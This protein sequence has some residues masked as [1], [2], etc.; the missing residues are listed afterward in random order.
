MRMESADN[1][2]NPAGKLSQKYNAQKGDGYWIIPSTSSATAATHAVVF[3]H[4]GKDNALPKF[5]N[6]TRAAFSFL[7]PADRPLLSSISH[8]IQW[9]E[10]FARFDVV[11]AGESSA[12][13]RIYPLEPSYLQQSGINV[14][15][16][17]FDVILLK[18][19]RH[20]LSSLAESLDN[21][22]GY[23]LI[24]WHICRHDKP[25]VIEKPYHL[26][27]VNRVSD[28]TQLRLFGDAGATKP[29][30][31]YG[32]YVTSYLGELIDA[33]KVFRDPNLN[34]VS[35]PWLEKVSQL[36]TTF[37]GPA[38]RFAAEVDLSKA[39]GY[40]DTGLVGRLEQ[41]R[42]SIESIV[43]HKLNLDI[44]QQTASTNIPG[45]IESENAASLSQAIGSALDYYRDNIDGDDFQV[46]RF[47]SE[48]GFSHQDRVKLEKIQAALDNG[49]VRVNAVTHDVFSRLGKFDQYFAEVS[50]GVIDGDAL[51]IPWAEGLSTAMQLERLQD[52][53]F[54]PLALGEVFDRVS[55][56]SAEDVSDTYGSV[57]KSNIPGVLIGVEVDA[58]LPYEQRVAAQNTQIQKNLDI[59]AL[60]LDPNSPEQGLFARQ[61]NTAATVS[62][63]NSDLINDVYQLDTGGFV[64]GIDQASTSTH[65][66]AETG[67][68]GVTSYLDRRSQN[69]SKPDIIGHL[70][71]GNGDASAQNLVVVYHELW[72]VISQSR[73][74]EYDANDIPV[75]RLHLDGEKQFGW[76]NGFDERIAGG[77]RFVGETPFIDK[78]LETP[79]GWISET[80][81]SEARGL[82]AELFYPVDAD[83]STHRTSA[84]RSF[85]IPDS[86]IQ[87]RLQ[88][89]LL[90]DSAVYF[91]N[92]YQVF[93][94]LNQVQEEYQRL[95][96]LDGALDDPNINNNITPENRSAIADELTTRYAILE[97]DLPRLTEAATFVT[98]NRV[99]SEMAAAGHLTGA[100][101]E[102]AASHALAVVFG[103]AAAVG[104]QIPQGLTG[105]ADFDKRIKLEILAQYNQL[106]FDHYDLNPQTLRETLET[107]AGIDDLVAERTFDLSALDRPE[108]IVSGTQSDG[109]VKA[110]RVFAD[111]LGLSDAITDTDIGSPADFRRLLNLAAGPD[112]KPADLYD[113]LVDSV[114]DTLAS[115]SRDGLP[116]STLLDQIAVQVDTIGVLQRTA[117]QFN[118]VTESGEKLNLPVFDPDTAPKGL[119]RV[120]LDDGDILFLPTEEGY[121]AFRFKEEMVERLTWLRRGEL[122]VN[123]DTI[124]E[125]VRF[126][127]A[128]TSLEGRPKA[129]GDMLAVKL[130]N[131]SILPEEVLA[132]PAMKRAFT[133]F[134][135]D[136]SSL[137]IGARN[138]TSGRLD[139]N[140]SNVMDAISLTFGNKPE[141]FIR[142]ILDVAPED[143]PL[144]F[145]AFPE[146]SAPL[147]LKQQSDIFHRYLNM[148]TL[149]IDE[150]ARLTGDTS[151][152]GKPAAD[153]LTQVEKIN[154]DVVSDPNVRL[155]VERNVELLKAGISAIHEQQKVLIDTARALGLDVASG[156]A[157]EAT[158]A[159]IFELT[160]ELTTDL[161]GQFDGAKSAQ[162]G[163]LLSKFHDK[164][165]FTDTL[166]NQLLKLVTPEA[167]F[168]LMTDSPSSAN[169]LLAEG[170][171]K[172]FYADKMLDRYLGS[173][174]AQLNPAD[175][176]DTLRHILG[177]G[178]L[179]Q[180]DF[181]GDLPAQR[182][183]IAESIQNSIKVLEK[184]R[185][186]FANPADFDQVALNWTTAI[187][188]SYDNL[189][190]SSIKYSQVL[191]DDTINTLTGYF[192]D[193]K[194]L[195]P[196]KSQDY[197]QKVLDGR[198][199]ERSLETL[200]SN[201]DKPFNTDLGFSDFAD[202]LDPGGYTP[203]DNFNVLEPLVPEDSFVGRLRSEFTARELGANFL[204]TIN[205]LRKKN[206]LSG[207]WVPILSSTEKLDNGSYQVR[208]VNSADD[209][210]TSRT[211]VTESAD[212]YRVREFIDHNDA[213]VL[214]AYKPDTSGALVRREDIADVDGINGLNAAFAVHA[215]IG[216]FERQRLAN[217]TESSQLATVLRAHEYLNLAQTAYGLAIDGFELFKLVKEGI[218]I[219]RTVVKEASAASKA[220]S[221]AAS[222]GFGGIDVLA[223]LASA[224]LDIYEL[225]QAQTDSEKAIIGTQLAFD[226][227][228]VLLGST[229]VGLG[230]TSLAA[231]AAEATAVAATAATAG[232]LIG[233]A[234]VIF[235]G[236]GIGITALVQAYS[237][238]AENAQ[239]VG[240]F[241]N[242]IDNTYRHGG[243]VYDAKKGIAKPVGQGIVDNVDFVSGKVH[244]GTHKIYRTHHG[245]TGSGKQNYFFWSG[246]FPTLVRD[247]NQAINVRDKIG[248]KAD[249]K[250]AAQVQNAKI[251]IAPIAPRTST[252]SYSWNTLP[253]STTRHDT[254]FDVIRR[255]EN[256]G[257]FDYD[258]YIFPSEYT[259]D[260]VKFD[261]QRTNVEINLDAS[262]R[263]VV[264]PDIPQ[265]YIGKTF[266][267]L[268]GHGGN[269]TIAVNDHAEL[270]VHS[271]EKSTW[272]L[273]M[274]N[275]DSKDFAVS[276]NA[277]WSGSS[278]T[279]FGDLQNA[280]V[281]INTEDGD[282]YS[283]DFSHNRGI[284]VYVNGE[285]V[286]SDGKTTHL[287]RP[288]LMAHLKDLKA[289]GRT[290]EFTT[291][292]HYHG[293]DGRVYTQAYF[294]QGSSQVLYESG[295]INAR[296]IGF[297]QTDGGADHSRVAFFSAGDRKLNI[298]DAASHKKL[299]DY[300]LPGLRGEVI[301]LGAAEENGVMVTRIRQTLDSG[302][303]TDFLFHNDGKSMVL[304]SIIG[305][306][307]FV[308]EMR[309]NALTSTTIRPS[310]LAKYF[311][312]DV[313]LSPNLRI[314][315]RSLPEDV[316]PQ[317][318]GHFIDGNIYLSA[319]EHTFSISHSGGLRVGLGGGD[320]INTS[321]DDKGKPS[322]VHFTADQ[323][324]Y[325]D[326]H[327]LYLDTTGAAKLG[328]AVDGESLDREHFSG[329][330]S[331]FLLGRTWSV[332]ASVHDINGAY[333]QMESHP[334]GVLSYQI[335]V[336][337]FAT[338]KGKN[339]HIA[340]FWNGN[341]TAV[342]A[343]V[344]V[345]T[346]TGKVLAP[347]IADAGLVLVSGGG[348]AGA[349]LT[350]GGKF[351]PA[352][353]AGDVGSGYIYFD[354]KTHQL[355]TQSSSGASA[356]QMHLSALGGEGESPIRSILNVGAGVL[357]Q[358]ESGVSWLVTPSGQQSLVSVSNRWMASNDNWLSTL[359]EYYGDPRA[360]ALQSELGLT[361]APPV[362]LGGMTDKY[363]DSQQFHLEG[364]VHY[365]SSKLASLAQAEAVVKGTAGQHY[366]I[367]TLDFGESGGQQ[368]TTA[369]LHN[370]ATLDKG[371]DGSHV[372]DNAVH[373]INGEIYLKAGEHTFDVTH[374]DGIRLRV[375]GDTVFSD[376]VWKSS[377]GH[378]KF[379]AD[380][381]GYYQL[382]A[383]YFDMDGPSN[384]KIVIDGKT[385]SR[386]NFAGPGSSDVNHQKS[387][388]DP[389]SGGVLVSHVADAEQVRLVRFDDDRETAW[390]FDD[391]THRLYRQALVSADQLG[392]SVGK[393]SQVASGTSGADLFVVASSDQAVNI[394]IDDFSGDRDAIDLSR[395]GITDINDV[396]I[397]T[398]FSASRVDSA[399]NPQAYARVSLPNDS[400]LYVYAEGEGVGTD[401]FSA[402]NLHISAPEGD[403]AHS[404]ALS[405]PIGGAAVSLLDQPD[406]NSLPEAHPI[407]ADKPLETAV[408]TSNGLAVFSAEGVVYGIHDN[409]LSI[410][411]VTQ[412]WLDAGS[413]FVADQHLPGV[414]E[415]FGAQQQVVGWYL[416]DGG[417]EIK[418]PQVGSGSRFLGYNHENHT[419]FVA[420]TNAQTHRDTLYQVS[421]D[422]TSE[423]IGDFDIAALL[424][425]GQ[426]HALGLVGGD[427]SA[428]LNIP[429]LDNARHLVVSPAGADFDLALTPQVLDSYSQITVDTGSISASANGGSGTIHVSQDWLAQPVEL[430]RTGDDLTMLNQ[431][432]GHR[433]VIKGGA[434]EHAPKDLQIV[435]DGD[436]TLS[437]ADLNASLAV[438]FPDSKDGTGVLSIDDVYLHRAQLA[439][440]ADANTDSARMILS[441]KDGSIASAGMLA[442]KFI[443]SESDTH[444]AAANEVQEPQF[445]NLQQ[446]MA[447]FGG[448][449]AGALNTAASA[450]QS[451]VT[452]ASSEQEKEHALHKEPV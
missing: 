131:Y 176:A 143:A 10:E 151:L 85:R 122:D 392:D 360:V 387:W 152:S 237:R 365:S 452:L 309:R 119:K 221:A 376:D 38:L 229:S 287:V 350:K 380:S 449:A 219:G 199:R 163:E 335:N 423:A 445:N 279:Q 23:D 342:A 73:Y 296:L 135:A 413:K 284:A 31:S 231:T 447:G 270:Y 180:L 301:V 92:L 419:A 314:T 416:S 367:D 442:D 399:G 385:L 156:N 396:S 108:G 103:G 241:F 336:L 341:A 53:N 320:I 210:A 319:G 247:E 96:V 393:V 104:Q 410:S 201:V 358:D 28:E 388:Y 233:G 254:G 422:G 27:A 324:G 171:F 218:S 278:K 269:Y 368:T 159:V 154:S 352:V 209:E 148:T 384:L 266:H 344:Y 310:E 373:M 371:A 297:L 18:D 117:D 398:G 357:A 327:A 196:A 202:F 120:A 238:V 250:L 61:L 274:S 164:A 245:S 169:Q 174:N 425:D 317:H 390:L 421:F 90:P 105:L 125:S 177:A 35:L 111:K 414:L 306:A 204:S 433:L 13:Y 129:L 123:V 439:I 81:Y 16:R 313:R 226:S 378:G 256:D 369:F 82:P 285:T 338:S 438:Q 175:S 132:A 356:R 72:H 315:Q 359:Q 337:D 49:N 234:G 172:N 66:T 427:A 1:V 22:S 141:L 77:T 63:N 146:F 136:T 244:F 375:G 21:E 15:E 126:Y 448:N 89:I 76:T 75:R 80:T 130:L 186:S 93:H 101:G 170:G 353:G 216:F 263:V 25:A 429:L 217:E 355:Y 213:A 444:V 265:A 240:K 412:A 55:G 54:K 160:D 29:S 183:S 259:I 195:L 426:T 303:K 65:E 194:A 127:Q 283:A 434:G 411:G 370:N 361:Y 50:K 140:L 379:T 4:G 391:K 239:A 343:P 162:I 363:F 83:E 74:L 354:A 100:A 110:L 260:K 402:D 286:G 225:T 441:D 34:T 397:E 188:N 192:D 430:A 312:T 24:E 144:V 41:Y 114:P 331:Q 142:K 98:Y 326:F 340:D 440:N 347:A 9:Q 12:D 311:W 262:D 138:D 179:V 58:N 298:V 220:V 107:A 345:V 400:Y 62:N 40:Y 207:D 215:L 332:P 277:V 334:D 236:L 115:L 178:L 289:R 450:L 437:L 339:S 243:F 273:S 149:A 137:I 198:L 17:D 322:V 11:L 271:E 26:P 206:N 330:D 401:F 203:H 78:P 8:Y 252:I 290:D 57:V 280:N 157:I 94:Y 246:D 389:L 432:T 394:V 19:D 304:D 232:T 14:H 407:L 70:T 328:I 5:V 275:L 45:H 33:V 248:Y 446:S 264:I 346:D 299:A 97:K 382:D 261:Y 200:I 39:T 36:Q 44:D 406:Q 223:G 383:L 52:P 67:I 424:D 214:K 168:R 451:A 165:R 69:Q 118:Y 323:E 381:D 321:G 60:G 166:N 288:N 386:E 2:T 79:A 281:L 291:I 32:D 242:E 197:F 408:S 405:A 395:W 212:I 64:F 121:P 48:F 99:T 227:A 106:L 435:T 307:G 30:V 257:K 329:P 300:A 249:N 124:S 282:V 253:G 6:A 173:A 153:V 224:G 145:R 191:D 443:A 95:R 42:E 268:H 102:A 190:E 302:Q 403:S 305:D 333:T 133:A 158:P 20:S 258:F 431:D 364:E 181:A 109:H 222:I 59:L 147:A 316:A 228:G 308:A 150:L 351:K 415:V 43:G 318:S 349:T 87:E 86:L 417:V 377:A 404:I 348:R 255:L 71:L 161:I 235:A 294:E 182:Q 272:I 185:N 134:V 293:A 205:G 372:H 47:K 112:G 193:G 56:L 51:R 46:E 409:T 88:H 116:A 436:L 128:L 230:I 211:L 295:N 84:S 91:S 420:Q 184:Y 428:L 113:K 7:A 276:N 292:N 189:A 267:N 167:L 208:F 139:I 418:P 37:D 325:Y 187:L 155:Q 3:A 68:Q 374:D 251:F 362:L 366:Q